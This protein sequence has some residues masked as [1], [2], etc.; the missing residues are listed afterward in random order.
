MQP[1]LERSVGDDEGRGGEHEYGE[2]RDFLRPCQR[3]PG[4]RDVVNQLEVAEHDRDEGAPGDLAPEEELAQVHDREAEE[5]RAAVVLGWRGDFRDCEDEENVGGDDREHDPLRRLTGA[6][7]EHRE[8][9]G[10]EQVGDDG[11]DAR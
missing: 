7:H 4:T 10:D 3:S 2:R 9:H 6:P 1:V 11:R 8:Q 5:E